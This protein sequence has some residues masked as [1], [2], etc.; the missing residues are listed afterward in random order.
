MAIIN[1]YKKRA[2][3]RSVDYQVIMEDLIALGVIERND[4][5]ELT[6]NVTGL[7]ANANPLGSAKAEPEPEPDTE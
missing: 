5:E 2:V 7:L 3:R 4:Y 6:N 1:E